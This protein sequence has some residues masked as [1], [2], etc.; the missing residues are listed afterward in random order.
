MTIPLAPT[1]SVKIKKHRPRKFDYIG[2][3]LEGIWK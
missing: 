1:R 3:L 2:L